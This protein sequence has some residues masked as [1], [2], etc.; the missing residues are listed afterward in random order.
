MSGI[1]G[2]TARLSLRARLLAGTAIGL[3]LLAVSLSGRAQGKDPAPVVLPPLKVEGQSRDQQ[4]DYKTDR[5]SLNKLTEPLLDTPQ[6]VTV[7][8][9][10]VIE[11]RGATTM[12]DVLR[13]VAGVSL[14]A[15]E[16]GAQ[17]DSLTLRGFSARNDIFLD[18]MK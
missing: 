8:P 14:A 4:S 3:T 15:G 17:G 2:C 12:R 10:Q 16:G 5:P 13:N 7:V 1:C 18:G 11:D 9:Q 6:S